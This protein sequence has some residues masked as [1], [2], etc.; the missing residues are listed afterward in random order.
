MGSNVN[1]TLSADENLLRKAREIARRQGKSLNRMIRE[2]LESLDDRDA[3]RRPIED[4]FVLM[5]E[6]RGS[7]G[8]KRFDRN[9]SHE[10]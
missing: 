5:D 4:L 2:Y 3:G 6:A 1:I 7:L 8:G 10:R 9:E